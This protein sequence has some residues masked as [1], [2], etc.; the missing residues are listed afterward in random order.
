MSGNK[1][2]RC[3]YANCGAPFQMTPYE[4][5]YLIWAAITA[6]ATAATCAVV[7]TAAIFTYKQVRE[8]S[9]ARRLEGALA[10]LTHISSPD[11][12][13]ARLLVYA[14]HAEINRA[15]ESNPSWEEL[16]AFFKKISSDTVDLACFRSYLASLENVAILVLH[17]LAP[18]EI[19]EMYFARL[20]PH[21]WQVL[22]RF[23]T[24]MRIRYGASDYLQHFEMLTT[25][26]AQEGL[27]INKG[28]WTGPF[29]QIKSAKL[30]RRLLTDRKS[31]L[32]AEVSLSESG[33]S[34]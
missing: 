22:N 18:D 32:K 23:I 12:R 11:L 21:H 33:P 16:D 10:V 1:R 5:W 13:N 7:V 20:G 2:V 30:K 6:I 25:L 17:D 31:S 8:A 27:N 28:F 29:S 14:H 19:V 15:V 9:R 24:L 3:K 26:L 34:E 4:H